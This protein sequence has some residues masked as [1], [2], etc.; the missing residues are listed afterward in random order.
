V[1]EPEQ[2]GIGFESITEKIETASAFG[3]LVLHVFAAL[4]EFRT[5]DTFVR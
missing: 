5:L 2:Q 1:A 3:K 4:D